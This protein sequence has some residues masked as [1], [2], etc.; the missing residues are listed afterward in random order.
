M[1]ELIPWTRPRG[2]VHDLL[3][4]LSLDA[5]HCIVV[6]LSARELYVLQNWLP[7]DLEF[8][9]RYAVTMQ[10]AGY[11]PLTDDHDLVGAWLNFVRDFQ[12]AVDD[13]SCNIESG[14]NAIA[15][16][17]AL[18]AQNPG[19]SG[20]GCGTGTVGQVLGCL[21]GLPNEAFLPQPGLELTG[22]P[23]EGFE[24]WQEYNIYKCAAANWI[25]AHERATMAY[26][27]GLDAGATAVIVL[28]PILALIFATIEAPPVA[29]IAAIIGISI[30]IA[31][32]TGA[33]W[34]FLDQ[35]IQ[36][37]DA[38]REEIVCALFNSG[39]SDQ[40]AEALVNGAIDSIQSIVSWGALGPIS[41]E[42]KALLSEL[43]GQL[44]GNPN[45]KPLFEAVAVIQQ[46][47][48]P[49]AVDCDACLEAGDCNTN[50]QLFLGT[51]TLAFGSNVLTPELSGGQYK[52]DARLRRGTC[53]RATAG[54]GAQLYQY[55]RCQNGSY[56]GPYKTQ[57]APDNVWSCGGKFVYTGATAATVTLELGDDDCDDEDTNCP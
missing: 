18:M 22:N 30:E 40:A 3:H 28:G 41:T 48:D 23:P 44:I 21:D 51:G 16:A 7:L 19:G 13:V 9:S 24:T 6:C 31:L 47:L 49:A 2:A 4:L 32:L 36:D 53:L 54:P 50:N 20:G 56:A 11:E 10:N 45:V 34:W 57:G 14:L 55:Y 5:D 17:L 8:K 46:T 42:I 35:M 12:V 33:G 1:T 39:T 15:D 52:I 37:W 26:Y 43:F 27:R 29:A 25:W 38:K